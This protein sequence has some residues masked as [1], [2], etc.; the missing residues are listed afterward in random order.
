[1]SKATEKALA[2]GRLEAANAL[3]PYCQHTDR[4]A[5]FGV[6]SEERIEKTCNCGLIDLLLKMEG[7]V[8]WAARL[9]AKRQ[10]VGRGK[11]N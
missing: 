1:M 9:R 7:H 6:E 3:W 2:R 4:C 8:E 11:A 10:E 5:A